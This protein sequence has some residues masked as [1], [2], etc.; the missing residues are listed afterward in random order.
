M[1][2]NKSGLRGQAGLRDVSSNSMKQSNQ[3]ETS[4]SD[5]L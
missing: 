1:K 3:I 5:T 4:P 2:K